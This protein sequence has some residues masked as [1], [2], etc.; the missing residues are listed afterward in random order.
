[1]WDAALVRAAAP[2]IS[3]RS[4]IY[5]TSTHAKCKMQVSV[6]WH[7]CNDLV[8]TVFSFLPTTRDV[9]HCG[10][11]CKAW[12]A[13]AAETVLPYVSLQVCTDAHTAWLRRN[14]NRIKALKVY[15]SKWSSKAYR[16]NVLDVLP[17][18]TA[19]HTLELS[20]PI[21][22]ALPEQLGRLS[23]LHDLTITNCE[24]LSQLPA[25]VQYLSGLQH[26]HLHNC[27]K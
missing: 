3:V 2:T 6:A 19:A 13:A 20:D 15:L 9:L 8:A 14:I 1:M 12:R 22:S 7:Q 26:L 27:R 4:P 18:A 24:N 21:S 25:G 17:K 11:V 5:L 23:A 10:G 16:L